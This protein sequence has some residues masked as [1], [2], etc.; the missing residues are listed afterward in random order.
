M[1]GNGQFDA[2]Q[3]GIQRIKTFMFNGKYLIDDV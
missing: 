2:L 3:R 1:E